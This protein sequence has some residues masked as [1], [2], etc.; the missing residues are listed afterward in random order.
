MCRFFSCRV[1]LFREVDDGRIGGGEGGHACEESSMWRQRA[2]RGQMESSR[3][4]EF[5]LRKYGGVDTMIIVWLRFSV[6]RRQPFPLPVRMHI[7]KKGI[8]RTD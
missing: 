7:I 3:G 2:S 6:R 1:W 8:P 4:G 5:E